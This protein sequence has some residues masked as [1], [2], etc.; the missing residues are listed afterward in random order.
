MFSFPVRAHGLTPALD[1]ASWSLESG[2]T[3]VSELAVP[4]LNYLLLP[5]KPW[6]TRSREDKVLP[7]A[8]N[9]SQLHCRLRMRSSLPSLTGGCSCVFLRPPCP[10]VQRRARR[11]NPRAAG[12]SQL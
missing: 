8:G 3:A 2:L 12:G 5:R 10:S 11:A 1:H 4:L 6:P 9:D 7:Q